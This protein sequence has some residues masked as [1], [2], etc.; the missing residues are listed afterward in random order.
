ML[1]QSVANLTAFSKKGMCSAFS[2]NS[3]NTV[4]KNIVTVS[5][6]SVSFQS[7]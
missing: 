2:I 1:L 5:T 6:K 4:S 7:S 3:S